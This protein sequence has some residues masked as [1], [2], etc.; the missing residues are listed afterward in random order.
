MALLTS[1]PEVAVVFVHGFTGGGRSTWTG[2]QNLVDTL[3]EQRSLWSKCDLFFYDYWPTSQLAPLSEDFYAFL[4][5]DFRE[6]AYESI[7]P[8]SLRISA[9]V[10][11]GAV[12]Y[13][14]LVLVGHSAGAVI[15]RDVVMQ[16]VKA[17]D[18]KGTPLSHPQRD[19]PT[20][21]LEVLLAESSLRLF[22]PAHLGVL[23][24][25]IF[26]AAQAVPYLEKFMD[27]SLRASSLYQN[28]RPQSATLLNLQKETEALSNKYPRISA[29]K[30][31]MLFG[32]NDSVVEIG[33]YSQ[34]EFYGA[35]PG[36]KH[37]EPHHNHLSIC[38]PSTTFPK[39]M[40]FVSETF[41]EA[42]AAR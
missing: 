22:A 26:G 33:G 24:A 34:D 15:I 16:H 39:P 36:Q 37:T 9:R 35:L 1:E 14:H 17:L 25:G 8:S 41:R 38:K 10:L 11:R 5:G 6:Y 21:N 2:F 13:K 20:G 32:R 18:M 12:Q 40:Q 29:L 4:K 28:L 19:T 30:A 3:D 27:A 23:A 31:S 7:L 42:R